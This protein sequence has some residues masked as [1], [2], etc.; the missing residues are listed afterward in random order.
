M[1]VNKKMS[2]IMSI[3]SILQAI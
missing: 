1:F 3:V 2:L